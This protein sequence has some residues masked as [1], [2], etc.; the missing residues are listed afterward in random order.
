MS[1]DYRD[2]QTTEEQNLARLEVYEKIAT[3]QAEV[4]SGVRLLPLEE[5]FQKYRGKYSNLNNSHHP[6]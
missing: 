6:Q 3:S 2:S 1:C 4:A 5:V